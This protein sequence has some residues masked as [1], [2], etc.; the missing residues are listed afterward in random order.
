MLT[1]PEKQPAYKKL[2]AF[3]S[4]ILQKTNQ[5]CMD[6][7]YK[8]MIDELRNITW[9]SEGGMFITEHNIKYVVRNKNYIF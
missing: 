1:G 4:I 5:S 9:G 7:S 2:A 8:N 3:N 6:Y